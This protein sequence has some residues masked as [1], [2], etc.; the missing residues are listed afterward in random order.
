[1]ALLNS[2]VKKELRFPSELLILT[3]HV[4]QPSFG[5]Y[6]NPGQKKLEH[7]TGKYLCFRDVS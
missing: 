4:S 2:G 6:Y 3:A 7:C 5:K 1:M